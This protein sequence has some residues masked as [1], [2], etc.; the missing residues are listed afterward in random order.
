M[1]AVKI[2]LG[3]VAVIAVAFLA[4]AFIGPAHVHVEREATIEAPVAV[5]F[6]EVNSLQK[7][8]AWDPWQAIDPNIV[9]TYSGPESGVGNRNEWKSSHDSVGNGAQEITESIENQIIRTHLTF[10]GQGEADSAMEFTENG[11]RTGV[12]W[13]MD[14][15]IPFAGR[16][17]M[18]FI[19][20]DKA[21]GGDFERGLSSLNRHCSAIA[22][23]AKAD[24]EA[25]A[26]MAEEEA[27]AAESEG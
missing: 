26:A 12:K 9:N 16:P 5:V 10:D 6:A 15:D 2:I 8:S 13:S 20:M 3:I 24:A 27:A 21:I 18:L 7:W 22:A 19:D 23:Q 4:L 11:D 14:M 1:K 17:F 25:A